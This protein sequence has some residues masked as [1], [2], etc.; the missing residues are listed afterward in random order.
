MCGN[1]SRGRLCDEA[2]ETMIDL[3][4]QSEVREE[5]EE[6]SRVTLGNVDCLAK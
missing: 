3:R 6:W 2:V 1:I 5:L 4:V